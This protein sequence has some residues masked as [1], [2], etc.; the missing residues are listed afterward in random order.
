MLFFS[1]I[2]L[3]SVHFKLY[4]NVVP[5][6]GPRDTTFVSDRFGRLIWYR[7]I[8]S[9]PTYLCYTFTFTCSGVLVVIIAKPNN[10]KQPN[11]TY[12]PGG[13]YAWIILMYVYKNTFIFC[14][15][16]TIILLACEHKSY[17]CYCLLLFFFDP[18]SRHVYTRAYNSTC[19]SVRHYPYDH[20]VVIV[21]VL[22]GLHDAPRYNLKRIRQE[23][24]FYS[25]EKRNVSFWRDSCNKHYAERSAS[26]QIV[27]KRLRGTLKCDRIS[28][29]PKNSYGTVGLS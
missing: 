15:S 11:T 14:I 17:Y 25:Y 7:V 21:D 23:L 19:S 12:H 5:L 16:I 26:G 9:R 20:V 10:W 3:K 4:K 22:T 2:F 13:F 27:L 29:T 8:I 1:R 28:R 18:N 24:A 6:P